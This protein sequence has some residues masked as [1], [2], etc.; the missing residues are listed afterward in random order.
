[1]IKIHTHFFAE[2]EKNIF[3]ALEIVSIYDNIIT[4]M[5]IFRV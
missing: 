3:N 4:E 1:M 5:N 2:R